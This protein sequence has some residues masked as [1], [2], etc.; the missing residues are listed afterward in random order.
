[1]EEEWREGWKKR[2]EG[3]IKGRVEEI[4]RRMNICIILESEAWQDGKKD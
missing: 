3:Q 4:E 2:E 1:M